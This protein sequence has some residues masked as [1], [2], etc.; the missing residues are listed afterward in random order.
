MTVFE[1]V[2][3]SPEALGELLESL[4]VIESPWEKE[5]H[6]AFCA[7]CVK[8]DCGTCPHEKER[9]NP[10]WWLTLGGTPGE[11]PGLPINIKAAFPVVWGKE[12]YSVASKKKEQRAPCTCCDNTGKV[13]I[14]GVE[15]ECPR[16][17]GDWRE[18]EVVGET[19]VY[20]VAKWELKS[21][22]ANGGCYL[23]ARFYKEDGVFIKPE[24]RRRN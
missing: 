22:S 2:A 1:K 8:S 16:C 6:K 14:K 19:T 21:I 3:A 12:Y 24:V 5:F 13:T 23:V 9:N 18:R 20:S 4:A 15:Y 10:T 17:K 11:V 7:G